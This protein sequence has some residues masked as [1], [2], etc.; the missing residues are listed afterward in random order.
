[1][2]HLRH[3]DDVPGLKRQAATVERYPKVAQGARQL[4]RWSIPH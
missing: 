2:R 1:L 4:L 3:R